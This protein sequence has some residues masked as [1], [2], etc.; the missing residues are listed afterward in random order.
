MSQ[1]LTNWHLL[2]ETDKYDFAILCDK[3]RDNAEFYFTMPEKL[4]INAILIDALL[5]VKPDLIDV[6]E[7]KKN[8]APSTLMRINFK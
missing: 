7:I 1:E 6:E 5:T 3:I 4:R 8:A 2:A